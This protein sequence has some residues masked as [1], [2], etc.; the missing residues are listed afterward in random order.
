[1]SELGSMTK[2]SRFHSTATAR[3]LVEVQ[4]GLILLR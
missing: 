1:M 2:Q 4:N 3:T